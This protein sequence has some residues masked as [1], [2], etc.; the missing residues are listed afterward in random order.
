MTAAALALGANLGEARE[1]MREAVAR[2]GE[3]PQV[4]VTAVS[5]LWRT[6][7]IGGLEQPD[8]LNAVVLADTSLEPAA[9]LGLAHELEEAAGR[10]RSVR[11]GPRTLDVDILAFDSERTADPALTL[12][13]PRAHERSFVLAPWS[14]VDPQFVL[15]PVGQPGRTVAQWARTVGDQQVSLLDGGQWWR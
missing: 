6:A 1:R 10:V 5:G 9:L 13:H 8:F 4:V 15:T 12:P 14:E 11:W 3:H 2:L 7:A